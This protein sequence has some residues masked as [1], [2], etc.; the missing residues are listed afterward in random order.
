MR[1]KYLDAVHFRGKTIK[2]I[3][4]VPQDEIHFELDSGEKYKM[5]HPQDCCE[6]VSIDNIEGELSDLIGSPLVVAK[7]DSERGE[8]K[9]FESSTITTYTFETEKSKVIVR[10]LGISNGYYSESVQIEQIED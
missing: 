9:D 6:S 1:Y 5:F 2:S 7:E 8:E 3:F 4:I 10:W